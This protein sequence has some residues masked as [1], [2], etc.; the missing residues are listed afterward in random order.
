MRGNTS[1]RGEGKD[2]GKE[3]MILV[4]TLGGALPSGH[5]EEHRTGREALYCHE[6]TCKHLFDANIRTFYCLG[7]VGYLEIPKVINVS[8]RKTLTSSR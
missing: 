3:A 4:P 6:V 2:L 5:K 1:M 7:L 8:P